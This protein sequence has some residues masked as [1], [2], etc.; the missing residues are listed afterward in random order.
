MPIE[1]LNPN[2]LRCV[3][4]VVI[5]IALFIIYRKHFTLERRQAIYVHYGLP[6]KRFSS[7]KSAGIV[8][9]VMSVGLLL[10][11]LMFEILRWHPEFWLSMMF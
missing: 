10:M 6:V 11:F 4:Y 5:A 7:L 8:L 1:M 2:T 3:V 9:G